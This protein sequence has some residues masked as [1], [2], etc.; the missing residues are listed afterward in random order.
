M[1][2]NFGFVG[3]V[4]SRLFRSV[5]LIAVNITFPLYLYALHL[6]LISIGL[7]ILATMIFSIFI[8]MIGGAIG[9]RYGYKKSLLLSESIAFVGIFLLSFSTSIS[10]II[11]AVIIGGLSGGGGAARGTFSNGLMPFIA[12]NWKEDKER[13]RKMSTLT[14]I[15]AIGSVIGSIL[16]AL[17]SFFALQFGNILSYRIIFG[18]AAALLLFSIISLLFLSEIKRPKKTTKIMKP[19]SFKYILRII[20]ANSLGGAGVGM[21]IPILPLWFELSFGVNTSYIGIVFIIYYIANIIGSYM[22]RV[23]SFR[24]NLIKVI[25]WTRISNGLL[26]V[27]MA[28]SPLPFIAAF[29][30]I[31]RGISASFGTPARSTVTVRGID[32]EDYGTA[33]SLQG[34]T[35]RMSQMT[36]GASGYLLDTALP[37]P[38]VI[39]GILQAAS[40]IA[41]KK[42]VKPTSLK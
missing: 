31:I 40:G 11:I 12:N 20:M 9:D 10:L 32:I 22:A 21:S 6:N 25:S 19:Q 13:V 37:L 8:V 26:L 42:L 14:L 39:G 33:T 1:R 5:G 24:Y 2:G 3:L 35:T 4:L 18:I 34:I 7:V 16:V 38:F 36:S 41:Y 15:A 23:F 30:Y 27:A 17:H 28:L 29:L